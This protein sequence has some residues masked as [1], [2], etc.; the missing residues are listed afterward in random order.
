M[1]KFLTKKSVLTVLACLLSVS[2]L[3]WL[4]RNSGSDFLRIWRNVNNIYLSLAFLVSGVIYVFMGLSLRETLK[5]LGQKIN[6]GA[7]VS[8]AFV[9]TTVNYLVSSMGVSGF[10]LRAHLLGRRHIPL[11][12]SVVSSVVI[13]EIGRAHV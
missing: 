11:G 8:I 7:A 1:I 2:A 10:A 13:S 9:S 6:L 4:M 5:L 12:A 3:V